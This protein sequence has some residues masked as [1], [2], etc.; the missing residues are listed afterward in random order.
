MI[1]K[2]NLSASE[3]KEAGKRLTKLKKSLKFKKFHD[4]IDSVD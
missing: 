2:T 1:L 3:I 4:D